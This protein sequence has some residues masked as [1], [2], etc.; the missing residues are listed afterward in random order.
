MLST[1]K[2][3][4]E[5]IKASIFELPKLHFRRNAEKSQNKFKFE[6]KV[7]RIII[8]IIIY[9]YCWLL[10]LGYICKSKSI[11]GC[12]YS[13]HLFCETLAFHMTI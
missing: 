1:R 11:V 9:A 2:I 13:I 3:Y 12:I 5:K 8:I 7:L 10:G 6:K 4:Q